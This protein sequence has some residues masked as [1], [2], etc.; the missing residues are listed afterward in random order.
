[1][2]CKRTKDLLG[3]AGVVFTEHDVDASP[4]AAEAVRAL[5]YTSVPVVTVALPDGVDHWSGYR[6]D[7]ITALTY[8]AGQETADA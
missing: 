6:P 7:Q 4:E 3:R 5:G 8:L 2:P 1:M